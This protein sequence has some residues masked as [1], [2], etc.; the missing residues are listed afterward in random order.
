[1]NEDAITKISSKIEGLD[2][3]LYKYISEFLDGFSLVSDEH[4]TIMI[5]RTEND[6]LVYNHILKLLIANR[7][8]N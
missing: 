1:M 7:N 6:I 8:L 5:D 4:L 2:R 3:Q